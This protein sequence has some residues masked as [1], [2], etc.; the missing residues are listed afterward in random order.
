MTGR[1][2]KL[3]GIDATFEL[4]IVTGVKVRQKFIH[5]DELKD[6]TW[7]L[8]VNSTHIPD[9]RA[10]GGLRI[11][12]NELEFEGLGQSVKLKVAAIRTSKNFIRFDEQRDGTWKVMY[13]NDN[14]P[15]FA[16]LTGIRFVRENEDT[17]ASPVS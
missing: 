16:S 4:S 15:N 2:V 7:R 10:L 9:L 11:S 8:T 5:F 12:K 3:E 6:G 13:N 1:T 14:Y 17:L